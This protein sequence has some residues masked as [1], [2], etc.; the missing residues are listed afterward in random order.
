MSQ[1][2]KDV[3]VI[4]FFIGEKPLLKHFDSDNSKHLYMY[5]LYMNQLYI[6]FNVTYALFSDCL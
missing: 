3:E 4:L 2:F 1:S 6:H 5:K